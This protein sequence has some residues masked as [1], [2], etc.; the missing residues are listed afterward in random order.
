MQNQLQNTITMWKKKIDFEH[1]CKESGVVNNGEYLR[2]QWPYGMRMIRV[3]TG[4]HGLVI[5]RNNQNSN[6]K[7]SV[8][9][10]VGHIFS[11][12]NQILLIFRA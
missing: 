12:D 4:K 5:G 9:V 11:G 7:N 6:H 3:T 10:V 1:R 8:A 2:E